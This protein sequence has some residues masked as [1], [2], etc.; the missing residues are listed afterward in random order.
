MKILL[1]RP[2][3]E[4]PLTKEE[5]TYNRVWLPLELATSAAIL[6]EDGHTVS[7]LDGHALRL[8]PHKI[9]EKAKSF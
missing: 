6:E 9:A 5:A 2:S 4:Y 1:V 7:I 8:A 3:W